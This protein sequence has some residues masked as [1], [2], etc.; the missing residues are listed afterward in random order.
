VA[1]FL[2]LFYLLIGVLTNIL[3]TQ[4]G[5]GFGTRRARNE[6]KGPRPRNFPWKQ[7]LGVRF[8]L[9]FTTTICYIFRTTN[10]SAGAAVVSRPITWKSPQTHSTINVTM[11]SS[12]FSKIIKS[13]MCFMLITFSRYVAKNI[14][15]FIYLYLYLFYS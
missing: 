3:G 11:H 1:L 2:L 15:E 4:N 5:K 13:R 8:P 6:T 10:S 14:D 12:R 9:Y 7:A